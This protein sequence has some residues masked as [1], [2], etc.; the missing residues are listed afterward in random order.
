MSYNS[1]TYGDSHGMVSVV[2]HCQPVLTKSDLQ[3][4][5]REGLLN[6]EPDDLTRIKNATALSQQTENIMGD[7]L[8][9]LRED[10]QQMQGQHQ[11]VSTDSPSPFRDSIRDRCVPNHLL[12]DNRCVLPCI[13]L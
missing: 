12:R 13:P 2:F 7:T 8:G 6:Q 11:Q 9:Q 4:E 10:R 5:G 1:R 3:E